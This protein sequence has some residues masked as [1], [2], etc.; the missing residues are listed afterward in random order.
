[1]LRKRYLM[2]RNYM[3]YALPRSRTAWLANFLSSD[4]NFCW[5]DG[6]NG[7]HSWNDIASRFNPPINYHSV[8]MADTG[9]A[10]TKFPSIYHHLPTIVI[11]RDPEEVIQSL[12]NVF[13]VD[14]TTLIVTQYEIL[15]AIRADLV[16]P[17]QD[18][19]Q[20]LLEIWKF[21]NGPGFCALRAEQLMNLNITTNKLYGDTKSYEFF[22][23]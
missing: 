18:I 8:G 14:F 6:L 16:I 12:F 3:I 17:F 5:H 23:K 22:T 2:P 13:G 21:C 9:A 7:C 10:L 4:N 15:K 1:M 19:N 11:L 20:Q